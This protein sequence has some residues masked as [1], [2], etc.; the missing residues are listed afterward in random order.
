MTTN[1]PQSNLD[2]HIKSVDDRVLWMLEKSFQVTNNW[3]VLCDSGSCNDSRSPCPTIDTFDI[4]LH[5]ATNLVISNAYDAD[6]QSA[7]FW[8]M[9]FKKISYP[10]NNVWFCR[11]VAT[12]ILPSLTGA[13]RSIMCG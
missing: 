6:E 13:A 1:S 8:K 3:I 12:F 4:K 5:L 9:R 2:I 7:K 10:E 11:L